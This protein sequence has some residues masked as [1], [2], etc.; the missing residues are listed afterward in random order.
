MGDLF[1][2]VDWVVVL[3][4]FSVVAAVGL[5]IVS[6]IGFNAGLDFSGGILVSSCI[7]LAFTII[8]FIGNYSTNWEDWV[9]FLTWVF[10]YMVGIGAGAWAAYNWIGIDNF[11]IHW[12]CAIG[13]GGAAELIPERLLSMFVKTMQG[14]SRMAQPYKPQAPQNKPNFNNQSQNRPWENKQ[15]SNY[16]P[17]HRPSQPNQGYGRPESSFAPLTGAKKLNSFLDEYGNE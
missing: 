1:R 2:D 8:Q 17:Q 13:L 3:R 5:L 12:L 9:F 11:W 14:K 4:R 15:K 10:T 16:Q 6:Y 7:W